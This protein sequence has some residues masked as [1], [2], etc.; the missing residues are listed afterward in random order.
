MYPKSIQNLIE[1]FSKFPGIGPRQAT[2]LA[3]FVLKTENGFAKD[4]SSALLEIKN[5]TGFCRQCFKTAEKDSLEQAEN[6]CN[7][8]NSSNRD[9]TQIAVIEK[10]SDLQNIEKS[11]AYT[12][13][14]HVLGG[15]ISPLD[16]ESPKKLHLRDLVD[17][18]QG[19]LAEKNKLELVLATNPTTEG[20][21]TGLYIERVLAPLKNKYPGLVISRLARGLSLGSEIEYADESTLQNAL[22]NRKNL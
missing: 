4:L 7:I 8:C 11:G 18:V 9:K 3:F 5:K 13:V 10:E 19:V 15:T 16:P 12:G 21:T 14:Y 17:R 22:K 6:L 20:D 2:R 1:L